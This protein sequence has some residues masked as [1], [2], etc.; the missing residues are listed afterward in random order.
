VQSEV[1][2]AESTQSRK[3]QVVGILVLQMGIMIHSLVIG[4]TISITSGSEFTS[5]VTA[6]TFHQLFEGLS[7]G[8]RIATL[9]TSSRS[10]QSMLAI[11]FAFTVPIGIMIGLCTLSGNNDAAKMKLIQG[12]M[13]AIS[14]GM[15][16]YAACVEMLAGDFIMDPALWK[17]GI[18]KQFVAVSSLIVG[19]GA[20]SVV[21]LWS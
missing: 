3:R 1:P 16:I 10:L 15:L 14:A 21:G 9:P 5:L 7:L 8:T 11:S 20:M 13:A 4:L 6:I 17:S 12:L 2:V 19:A 18:G